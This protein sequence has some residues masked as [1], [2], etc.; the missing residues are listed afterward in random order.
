MALRIE[1]NIVNNNS[2]LPVNQ[3]NQQEKA[4][5]VIT[6]GQIEENK[7]V[8][9]TP[10]E[11]YYIEKS[12][13]TSDEEDDDKL[14]TS[15]NPD[16]RITIC[17]SIAIYKETN[18]ITDAMEQAVN[19]AVSGTYNSSKEDAYYKA[20]NMIKEK[21]P[22]SSFDD[23]NFEKKFN[24]YGKTVYERSDLLYK[25]GNPIWFN[26]K[27]NSI[28]SDLGLNY[29]SKSGNTKAMLFSSFAKTHAKTVDSTL[30]ENEKLPENVPQTESNCKSL[31]LFG[32]VQER[33]KNK[34]LGILSAFYI[35]DETQDSKTSNITACYFFNKYLAMTQGSLNLYKVN[36][37]KTISKLDFNISFNPELEYSEAKTNE[38]PKQ[39]SEPV[40]ETET[41]TVS[42]TNS[43]KWSKLFN[44]FFDTQAINGSTEEGLGAQMLFKRAGSDSKFRV[45][46][47]GKISTTQQEDNNQ[48]HVTF[49]SGIKYKKDFSPKSQLNAYVDVKDRIT[50]GHGNIT[51]VDAIVGYASPKISA[52]VE[53]KYINITQSN[54][55]NYAGIVG[56]VFYTPNKNVN[57]FTEL[58]YINMQEPTIEI[59]GTNLQAGV[60]VDF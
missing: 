7:S 15:V 24:I 1:N 5:A 19:R 31:G 29:K 54:S 42:A 37:Q 27:E 44:P 55:P 23:I 17:P 46:A 8:S 33:F 41:K 14:D 39:E 4:Q 48:Y 12:K 57:L 35:N 49:G 2:E 20:M 13:Q 43:K 38:T 26:R 28:K 9:E 30:L 40:S 47:F 56:R 59:S 60:V 11:G 52:E 36:N 3:S 10:V 34:D 45:G 32:V 51:T 58:S 6:V 18:E 53:G 50:F 21:Q 16:A 25:A 22:Y